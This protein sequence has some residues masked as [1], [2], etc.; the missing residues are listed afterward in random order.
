MHYNYVHIIM[1]Y[2]ASS[3]NFIFFLQNWA[4]FYSSNHHIFKPSYLVWTK[5]LAM[6]KLHLFENSNNYRYKI[7]QHVQDPTFQ[8]CILTFMV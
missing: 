6:R 8:K 3:A 7:K 2:N 1:H 4:V 5:Y